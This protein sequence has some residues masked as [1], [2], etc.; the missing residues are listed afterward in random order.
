ME[1]T[2]KSLST[3]VI[4]FICIIGVVII[5]GV[6]VTLL[7]RTIKSN[8]QD[9]LSTLEM[10]PLGYMDNTTLNCPDYWTVTDISKT[11]VTCQDENN[12]GINFNNS[13]D[14]MNPSNTGGTPYD[15]SNYNY[16]YAYDSSMN[17]AVNKIN[18]SYNIGTV[19]SDSDN[20]VKV[21]PYNDRNQN[22]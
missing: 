1:N 18:N 21:S 17:N 9:I 2:S 10:P 5:I 4:V 22:T 20:C 19:C 14:T 11:S 12:K 8:K 7:Y 6:S 15:P 13:I 3:F 16:P